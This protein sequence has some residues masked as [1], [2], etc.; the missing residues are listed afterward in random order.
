MS[1]LTLSE[2]RAR[3]AD[4]TVPESE[5]APYFV[6]DEGASDAFAPCFALNPETVDIGTGPE[7]AAR[8]ALA[9]NAANAASRLRRDLA[10]MSR[11]AG[12]Y[13]GPVIVAEGDSWW[14]YPLLL[15]DVIDHLS[16]PFAIKCLSAAGDL[17]ARMERDGEYLTALAQTRATILILSGGG[18]DLLSDGQLYHCL[19]DHKPGLRPGDYLNATFDSVLRHAL[20]DYERILRKVHGRFP[21]VKVIVHGYD[22]AIP[23]DGRWLGR[24]MAR[25]N[26]T[27]RNLQAAIAVDMMDR[28]NRGLMRLVETL[29]HVVYVDCRGAVGTA[30]AAWHDE[31]HPRNAGYGRVAARIEAEIRR[32]AARRR[33]PAFV[34]GPFGPAEQ[35]ERAAQALPVE[36]LPGTGDPAAPLGA[37]AAADGHRPRAVSLHVGVN[38]VDPRH[39]VG[40][41][42]LEGCEDD[43]RAMERLAR[44]AGYAT[45]MLLGEAA[46]REA[47]ILAIREAAQQLEAGDSFLLTVAAHGG[48]IPDRNRDEW[49]TTPGDVTDETLCLYDTQLVDD[50]LAA[51]WSLFRPGVRIAMVGDTCHAG[52]QIR[53][54]ELAGAA[55]Q[56]GRPDL[57]ARC[58]SPRMARD[59]YV[60]NRAHYDSRTLDLIGLP[61]LVLAH[62][63]DRPVR[64]A[65]LGLGACLDTQVAMET[66]L[67]GVFTQAL[68]R[69]WDDGRFAGNWHQLRARIEAEIASPVQIPALDLQLVEADPAFAEQVPFAPWPR[70][71]GAGAAGGGQAMGAPAAPALARS[72][73]GVAAGPG[74]EDLVVDEADDAPGDTGLRARVVWP[75]RADF[76][77]FVAGLGLRHFSAQELLVLGREHGTPGTCGFGKNG[78]PPRALWPNIAGTIGVLDA[79]R[80]R[81]GRA[82]TLTS[83]YR[84][85]AYNDCLPGAAGDSLH[86]RFNALDFTVSGVSPAA[87]GNALRWMRDRE[88]RFKGGIGFYQ[89]FV[90]VDTRG[91]NVTFRGVGATIPAPPAADPFA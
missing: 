8:S 22:Y 61:G 64:A 69:V 14:Q 34:S 4:P 59:T 12:G 72:R 19:A 56:P 55:V 76:D 78:F 89:T 47:V 49:A 45:R 62:P 23:N 3:L 7:A 1:R 29:P 28:F 82:I 11:L 30:P 6:L 42:D 35:L 54:A 10:F 18:N 37:E 57:R 91:E 86:M 65:V 5:L 21:Q 36:E 13:D 40:V 44:R 50:E 39:Y 87:A 27:D 16:K 26:I 9:L 52:T 84:A 67:G 90:H 63:L 17:L 51:L 41:T 38:R 75:D 53:A 88:G 48:M 68:L 80:A 74:P 77:A 85:K 20:A 81:L 71:D 2:L 79:L 66:M 60:A 70:D 73:G 58:L 31:L 46:T 33:L 25:R 15:E 83:A 24:P 32:L 43:A